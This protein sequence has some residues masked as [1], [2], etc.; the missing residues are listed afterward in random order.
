MTTLN[1][2]RELLNSTG[3]SGTVETK[4][5]SYDGDRAGMTWVIRDSAPSGP[6][7][8]YAIPTL[9]GKYAVPTGF[10]TTPPRPKVPSEIL[11]DVLRRAQTFESD[12]GTNLKWRGGGSGPMTSA[13]PVHKVMEKP[14]PVSCSH[15]SGMVAAGY[16]YNSTTYVV[17][18]NFRTGAYVSYGR[19]PEKMSIY[20]AWLAGRWFFTNGDMWA[21]TKDQLRPGDFAFFAEQDPEKSYA[22]ARSGELTPYFGNIFHVGIYLGGDR[23]IQSAYPTSPTGVYTTSFDA[24]LN[25]SLRFAVR[26]RWIYHGSPAVRV[27]SD[28][29]ENPVFNT[30]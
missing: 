14:Y 3:L 18:K 6:E 13:D 25:R 22:K 16:E 24:L 30:A 27:Q 12:G 19:P 5:W 7:L 10:A 4:G 23:I 8:S 21:C 1:N 9:D 29:Y 20:Q 17:D 11:R 26:P 28:G 2:A 15:F